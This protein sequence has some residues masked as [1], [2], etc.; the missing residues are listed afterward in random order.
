MLTLLSNSLLYK[1]NIVTTGKTSFK[2]V[3]SYTSA[4]GKEFTDIDTK[5]FLL[6]NKPAQLKNSQTWEPVDFEKIGPVR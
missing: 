1:V 2:I 5:N 4:D 6:R 3:N